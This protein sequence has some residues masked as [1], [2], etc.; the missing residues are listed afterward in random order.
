MHMFAVVRVVLAWLQA[1]ADMPVPVEVARRILCRLL[2]HTD[3]CLGAEPLMVQLVVVATL[4]VAMTTVCCDG[5]VPKA[6]RQ[7]DGPLL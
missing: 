4:A 7:T 1:Y 3:Y 2:V 5:T 6:H